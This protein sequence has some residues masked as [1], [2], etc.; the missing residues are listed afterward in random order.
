MLALLELLGALLLVVLAAD[1]FTNAVEW[2][3]ARSGLTSSAAGAIV[4]A[5]G[6][7][8]PETIVAVIALVILRDPRSQAIGIG[9]VIGA[10]FMLSTVVF[11][12]IGMLALLRPKRRGKPALDIPVAP[13][14][15]GG[16][17]FFITFAL[18]LA[19]SFVRNRL[20]HEAAALLVLAAYGAYL[21]YHLRVEEP[22][23]EATPPA[24]RIAPT[25]KNPSWT[26]IWIQ[27]SIALAI[28]S[29]ASRWLVASLS[30][31]ALV[32]AVSPLIIS[33]L[34]SPIATELPEASSVVLWM[35]RREDTLAMNNVLGAMMFQTSIACAI[36][37]L[38]TP[39]QLG[40]NAYAAGLAALSAVALLVITTLISRRVQPLAL[41]VA[42]LGYIAYLVLARHF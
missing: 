24:L 11:S 25:S 31:A 15:F 33:L 26:L 21:Y 22:E 30:Q 16:T 10:P 1:A 2:I 35:R 12:L 40:A 32:F 7:S 5:I 39:W 13:T 18:A 42:G 14:I 9:T 6:S 34:L 37:M 28:T 4:A 3:D 29:A 23:G 19:A 8:L 27:L 20:A 38:A 41:A 17:L 36:A